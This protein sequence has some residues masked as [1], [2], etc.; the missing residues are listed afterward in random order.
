M[1]ER[2]KV[3]SAHLLPDNRT[4]VLCIQLPEG[5]G[6]EYLGDAVRDTSQSLSAERLVELLDTTN[7][8][9]RMPH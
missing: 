2:I 6:P 9:T 4:V 8:P 5:V 7:A 3:T 1:S